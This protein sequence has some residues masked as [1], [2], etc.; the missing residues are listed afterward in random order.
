MEKTSYTVRDATRV[1]DAF[2][3]NFTPTGLNISKQD[4]QN[5]SC[6]V[7]FVP[8]TDEVRDGIQVSDTLLQELLEDD[9]IELKNS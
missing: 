7:Y 5:D 1:K 2:N 4:P 8:A 3:L 9:A 6:T